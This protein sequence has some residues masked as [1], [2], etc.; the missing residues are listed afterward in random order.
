LSR[1]R[2]VGG[3]MGRSSTRSVGSMSGPGRWVGA[4]A[5]GRLGKKEKTAAR[6]T[7]LTSSNRSWRRRT[8]DRKV[9]GAALFAFLLAASIGASAHVASAYTPQKGDGFGYSETT[10][11]N[12]GQGS[13]AG[14]TD[15]LQTTGKEQM[16]SVNGSV[17]SASYDYSYQYSNDQGSS[18]ASSSSGNFTWS[19]STFTYLNGTDN[20]LGFG[21]IPYSSPL[22]VWFAMNSSLP[23][24]STFYVLNS[25]FTVLSKNYSLQLPTEGRYV[26]TI[27]A[28]GTGQYQRNDV[29][30]NF[31]ASFTW[32]EYFDPSTGY[33]VGYSYVEQDDGQYQGQAGS[34]TYTDDLY[35]TSTS[36]PLTAA[37]APSGGTT[38]TSTS[39]AG[40]LGS[41][42]YLPYLAAAAVAVIVVAAI[43]VYAATRRRR[44]RGGGKDSLPKHSP[45]PESPPPGPTLPPPAASSSAPFQSQV[46]L[47]SKPPEQVVIREVAMVNCRYCGTLIPTTAET[48]PYCGA[49]RR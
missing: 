27:Q 14:Y 33:I 44:R 1:T 17:V 48:C 26:Q 20:E 3:V 36:Y 13:Y 45:T 18:T 35:V 49:P 19:S 24:G 22:Y 11:V 31:T 47:G 29:Y 23:V 46:D 39:Q 9:L 40:I 38:T 30:G 2:P 43:V 41:P 5:R 25:Q 8:N 16:D 4:W 10:T 42:S 6:L 7:L 21:G 32:Y 12:D 34:F 37:S 15:Q 28:E